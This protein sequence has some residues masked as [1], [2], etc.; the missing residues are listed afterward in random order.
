MHYWY[1]LM[2][3][4]YNSHKIINHTL[5]NIYDEIIAYEVYG[6]WDCSTVSLH[7][8]NGGRNAWAPFY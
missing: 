6:F 8:P 2:N 3:L 4:C 5:W 1:N 7:I